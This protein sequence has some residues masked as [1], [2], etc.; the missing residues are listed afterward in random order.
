MTSTRPTDSR[1][2]NTSAKIATLRIPRPGIPVFDRPTRK[3]PSAPS[4]HCQSSRCIVFLTFSTESVSVGSIYQ[5][6]SAVVI[7]IIPLP[8][9]ILTNQ[10]AGLGAAAP[11]QRAFSYGSTGGFAASA[12]IR[13]C[14]RKGCTLPGLP[15]SADHRSVYRWTLAYR[16]DCGEEMM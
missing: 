14:T 4:A 13:K 16:Y 2:G 9:T 5:T 8:G 10:P 12:T 1:A 11:P 15:L 6:C 7:L 3:A